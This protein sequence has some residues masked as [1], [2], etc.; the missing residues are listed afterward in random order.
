MKEFIVDNVGFIIL[1]L[2]SLIEIVPI[3]ISP[4]ELL[5]KKMNKQ[6]NDKVDELKKETNSKIESVDKKID[7]NHQNEC[8]IL[9]T[10]FV[11]DY[12]NGE[13]KT[14]NQWVAI[15]NLANEYLERGWNSEIKADVLFLKKEYDKLFFDKKNNM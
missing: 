14:H 3:K 15:I 10:N 7:V 12:L 6:L 8:K 11:Q 1:G 4:L 5:G 2:L 13:K 9:I